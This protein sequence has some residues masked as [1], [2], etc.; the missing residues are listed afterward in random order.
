MS[1]V[2]R[3]LGAM[4]PTCFFVDDDHTLYI[5]DQ[6]NHHV[7]KWMEGAKEGIILAGGNCNGNQMKQLSH[8]AGVV[9]DQLGQISVADAR[10]GRVMRWY[11]GAKERTIVSD[12]QDVGQQANQL[13]GP[14]MGLS[15]D[16]KGNLYVT[17]SLSNRIQKF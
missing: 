10:N 13:V 4:S 8:P 9:V 2:S 1:N 7:M 3:G 5:I 11:K 14:N 6:H 15:L 17:D 12:A 16:S